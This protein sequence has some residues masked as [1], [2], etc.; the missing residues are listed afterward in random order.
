MFLDLNAKKTDKEA[1]IDS[2]GN[3]LTYG[4]IIAEAETFSSL[5]KPRSVIFVLCRNDVGGCLGFTNCLLSCNVPL[6]LNVGMDSALLENLIETYLPAYIWKPS[7]SL[8]SGEVS[9]FESY[10]Y[11]LIATGNEVYPIHDDLSLLLTTSGSTGSP[12]LVRHSYSNIEAQA[13]NISAFFEIDETE[14]PLLDLPIYYTMGLS[15]LYSHLFVGATVLVTDKN[16]LDSEYWTFLNDNQV[17]SITN[18]PYTYELLYKLRFLNR[19]YPSI[20]IITQ[21]GG[22]LKDEIYHAFAEYAQ[23]TCKKFIPT[24]GQTEGTARMAY[25]PA[26]YSL[27]KTGCIGKA[28][29]GGRLYLIDENGDKITEPDV[30]GEMVYEG[31]NVTLGYALSPEDLALGDERHGVLKTGDMVKMDSDGFFYIVGRKKRFLK[32]NGHRVGLDECEQII[33]GAFDVDCACTGTD[34]KLMCYVD[35]DSSIE[36]IRRHLSEVTGL[37]YMYFEV[38]CLDKIPRS[39]TGKILYSSLNK[40]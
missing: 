37:N 35:E 8:K 33:K 7:E 20:R 14:R 13:R 4:D 16:V 26:E 9:I 40:E 38:R 39:S 3:V 28:I 23:R 6:L 15:V 32:L 21:G 18:I 36:E 10:G 19:E 2:D 29:P 1:I 22:K 12:K 30:M 24:Y 34:K 31:P 27:T 5:T 11:A 25:L 17:T